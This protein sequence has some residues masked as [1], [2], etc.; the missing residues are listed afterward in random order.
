MELS[1]L[2]SPAWTEVVLGDFDR[3][4]QDHAACERKASATGLAFVNRYGD[5]PWLVGPMIAFAQEELEHFGQVVALLEKRGLSVGPDQ[6]DPYVGALRAVLRTG[7]EAHLLDRLLVAAVVEARGC[8][9]FALVRDALPGGELK[10]FYED[11]VRSE[12]RHAG[13]FQRL[14]R[15]RFGREL[16]D[17][18]LSELIAIEGEIVAHLELRPSLH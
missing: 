5:Q 7:K 2:T 6:K 18:R 14:A 9:R 1:V 8:E 11:I 10:T 3:F 4:L 15:H 12:A 13:L 16:V 17:E